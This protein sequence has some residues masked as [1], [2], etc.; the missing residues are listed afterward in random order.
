MPRHPPLSRQRDP[1][2]W[3]TNIL[4]GGLPCHKELHEHIY[5]PPAPAQ[6]ST[7]VEAEGSM[8]MGNAYFK[9]VF[10]VI[11]ILHEHI[12][13]APAQASTTVKAA[14]SMGSD[15]IDDIVFT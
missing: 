5:I 3:A 4:G 9:G 12:P 11:N 13:P 6:A 14:G 10:H 8:E 1:W 2:K 7:A 15:G